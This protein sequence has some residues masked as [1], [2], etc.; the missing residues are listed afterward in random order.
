MIHVHA[1]T[2]IAEELF[3]SAF[4]FR[5]IE[6][7]LQFWGTTPVSGHDPG[8]GA[9]LRFWGHTPILGHDSGFGVPPRF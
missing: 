3:W 6:A 7:R 4:H 2:K 8:N 9:R 5:T 1:E